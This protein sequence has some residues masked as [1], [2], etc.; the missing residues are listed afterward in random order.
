MDAVMVSLWSHK[1]SFS[2]SATYRAG[3]VGID[4]NF[5]QVSGGDIIERTST[6]TLW[7]A[8]V[9]FP[10]NDDLSLYTEG[11]W[12]SHNIIFQV[13]VCE[14]GTHQHFIYFILL[15]GIWPHIA[16]FILVL[17]RTGRTW[18]TLMVM[19]DRTQV[20]GMQSKHLPAKALAQRV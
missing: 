16:V 2:V 13:L 6:F 14:I 1:T 8:W 18:G 17:C 9:P 11:L 4:S 20:S 7:L 10:R 12:K 19:G 3:P 5:H 15:F